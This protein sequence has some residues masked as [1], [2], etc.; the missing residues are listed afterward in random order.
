MQF[1]K[2]RPPRQPIEQR[3]GMHIPTLPGRT[4]EEHLQSLA[5][6][7]L[8]GWKHWGAGSPNIACNFDGTMRDKNLL[9]GWRVCMMHDSAWLLLF[10][11]HSRLHTL[12]CKL[13]TLHTLHFTLHTPHSTLYTLHST[14][15]TSHFTLHTLHFTLSTPHF[16]LH[17]LHFTLRTPPFS[18]LHSL[19]CTGTVTGE[20]CR[21]FK[22]LV[23]QKCS[24]WLH[25]GSWAA[26]CY[27]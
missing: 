13:Y 27:F 17:T 14:L 19:Q 26:S 11:P 7:W 18:A 1:A 4:G 20:K 3:I 15:H 25:S 2:T 22:Q 16:T 5:S 12:H 24:T 8:S 23:S 6:R 9:V 21:L 10:T